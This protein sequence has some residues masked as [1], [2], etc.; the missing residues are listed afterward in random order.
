MFNLLK[1]RDHNRIMILMP[2]D[3]VSVEEFVENAFKDPKDA[4]VFNTKQTDTLKD[5]LD[6]MNLEEGVDTSNDGVVEKKPANIGKTENTPS[7]PTSTSTRPIAELPKVTV[8]VLDGTWK[9]VKG[10]LNRFPSTIT[11]VRGIE[12]FEYFANLHC[13]R[14]TYQ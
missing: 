7:A 12:Y 6:N 2:K 14:C 4:K 1:S 11:K 3:S 8:V 13:I 9:Q 5:Y 10:L